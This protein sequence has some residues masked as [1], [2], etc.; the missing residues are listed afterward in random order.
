MVPYRIHSTGVPSG[1][2]DRLFALSRVSITG[3]LEMLRDEK[4]VPLQIVL[5]EIPT[6]NSAAAIADLMADITEEELLQMTKREYLQTLIQF[7]LIIVATVPML[8][9]Y[10]FVQKCFVCGVMI[11]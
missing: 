7:A 1:R 4:L 10:R 11:S 2:A 3:R 8:V 6:M 9:V 5:R